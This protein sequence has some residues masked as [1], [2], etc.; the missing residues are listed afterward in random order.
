MSII[1][2]LKKYKKKK[3]SRI[4]VTCLMTPVSLPEQS[5]GLFLFVNA[6]FVGP[7]SIVKML[8]VSGC[9]RV[10]LVKHLLCKHVNL[11]YIHR[12]HTRT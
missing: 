9:K 10:Q 2:L 1:Q 7:L 12:M 3:H 8:A 5:I 4:N 6:S 11:H